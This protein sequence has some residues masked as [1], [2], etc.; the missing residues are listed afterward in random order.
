MESQN[1]IVLGVGEVGANLCR[2]LSQKGHNVVAVD[3]NIKKLQALQEVCDIQVIEGNGADLE[4]LLRAGIRESQMLM[5]VTDNDEANLL[6]CLVAKQLAPVT[7]IARLKKEFY[8]EERKSFYRNALGIDLIVCPE[9]LTGMEIV[10]HVEGASATM[11]EAL[12]DGLVEMKRVHVSQDFRFRGEQIKNISFPKDVLIVAIRRNGR[13][14]IPHGEDTILE[15][16]DLYLLGKLETVEKLD[17]FLGM[18]KGFWL[19]SKPQTAVIVGGG[20]IGRLVAKILAIRGIQVKL[21]EE[22]PVKCRRIAEELENVLVICADGTDI[23]IFQEEH[24]KDA[25]HF[26]AASNSDATNVLASLLAKDVGI[27]NV[28]TIVERPGYG[29]VLKRLGLPNVESPRYVT[30]KF[31]LNYIE[32]QNTIVHSLDR[33]SGIEILELYVE[34]SSPV[35]GKALK[36]ISFPKNTLVATILRGDQVFVPRGGDVLQQGDTVILIAHKDN[37]PV[38]RKMF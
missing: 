7:T 33:K 9:V 19:F 34:S 36:D 32:H 27:P 10:Y 30:A 12:A 35:E 14:I 16:D 8:F 20:R 18:K 2:V 24:L 29:S 4:I 25:Q 6:S 5:A 15:G 3:Q 23:H 21:I 37:L 1:V 31:I 11:V 22:D 28:I 13:T 26:I 17:S 38:L